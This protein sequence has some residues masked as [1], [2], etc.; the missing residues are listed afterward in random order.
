V[1][2]SPGNGSST[3]ALSLQSLPLGGLTLSLTGGAASHSQVQIGAA[4]P[5]STLENAIQLHDDGTLVDGQQYQWSVLHSAS[6]LSGISPANFSVTEDF[7][8]I[9]TPMV[10]IGQNDIFVTFTPVPEPGTLALGSLATVGWIA[11]W[12]RRRRAAIGR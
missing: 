2:L 6:A 9:G 10:T 3:G 7:G 12:R 8:T 1:V 11:T 5:V 4:G